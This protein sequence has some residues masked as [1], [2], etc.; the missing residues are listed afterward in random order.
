MSTV[1]RTCDAL[2]PYHGMSAYEGTMSSAARLAADYSA[3]IKFKEH[4]V[5]LQCICT[6][7]YCVVCCC[8]R[9][10]QYSAADHRLLNAVQASVGSCCEM[11][12]CS[13]GSSLWEVECPHHCMPARDDISSA[14]V[15]R[16]LS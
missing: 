14:T 2:M 6:V 7:S 9:L 13:H 4:S 16:Q 1:S 15:V 12:T 8:G 5:L 3:W 10:L 11:S